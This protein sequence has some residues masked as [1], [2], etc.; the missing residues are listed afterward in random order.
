MIGGLVEV[1]GKVKSQEMIEDSNKSE[2]EVKDKME[3][4]TGEEEQEREPMLL[5]KWWD[6]A[7]VVARSLGQEEMKVEEEGPVAGPN[8]TQASKTPVPWQEI[9]EPGEWSAMP[10][11]RV[12]LNNLEWLCSNFV[13]PMLALDSHNNLKQNWERVA[14]AEQMFKQEFAVAECLMTQEGHSGMNI[15]FQK[16]NNN[17]INVIPNSLRLKK[18]QCYQYHPKFFPF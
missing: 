12:T 8:S 1:K 17:A 3:E 16:T 9:P 14:A 2:Q 7:T 15:I 18:Q 10:I 11:F 4:C 13:A 6:I 5:A